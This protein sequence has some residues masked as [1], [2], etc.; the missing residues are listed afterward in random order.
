MRTS[1]SAICGG[2]PQG[3]AQG[4]LSVARVVD[5]ELAGF[6]HGAVGTREERIDGPHQHLAQPR[7]CLEGRARHRKQ[8]VRVARH[9][10]LL[11]RVD[12]LE[13]ARVGVATSPSGRPPPLRRSTMRERA[14]S[15]LT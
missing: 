14:S 8:R 12:L 6:E 10:V 5:H 11:A 13:A 1:S 2:C 3:H 9:D 7:G 4:L 15:P